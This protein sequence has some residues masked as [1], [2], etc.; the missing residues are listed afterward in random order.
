M[1]ELVKKI[2]EGEEDLEGLPYTEEEIENK[3]KLLEFDWGEFR[4]LPGEGEEEIN[5]NVLKITVTEEQREVILKA[6]KKVMDENG[7]KEG[8]ALELI[9]ADYLVS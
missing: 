6:I 4:D 1:A 7:V 2:K 3:I 8:R 5:V 9:C